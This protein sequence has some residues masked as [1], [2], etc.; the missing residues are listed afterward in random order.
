MDIRTRLC[1]ELSRRLLKPPPAD[2]YTRDLSAYSGW[3]ETELRKSWQPFSDDLVKGRDVLDF[4][5]GHGHLAIHLARKGPRSM[6]GVDIRAEDLELARQN[7]AAANLPVQFIMGAVSGIP[8]IAESV[9]TIVA[10][11]MVEHIMEPEAIFREWYRVLRPGGR[12]AI[13]WFPFAGAWGPHMDSLIP[14]PWAHVIFGERAMFTAAAAIYDMP[15][16]MPRLWD[17]ENG[18]KKPNKWRQWRTFKEQGYVNE[19]DIPT[20]ERMVE[21]AGFE[22]GRLVKRG[23][24]GPT[25]RQAIGKALMSL[26]LVGEYF[27][28]ST[29]IELV[30]PSK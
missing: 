16:F 30:K 9:D 21:G 14:I 8:M 12:V 11:D 10:F 2:D 19:L 13:E 29:V 20:F 4:G 17:I 24:S 25:W 26:P 27:C 5:C 1:F 7:A 23:F 28:V 18:K 6:T 3:R 15:T 22:I